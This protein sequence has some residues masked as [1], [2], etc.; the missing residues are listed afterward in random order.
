MGELGLQPS[1]LNGAHRGGC[2]G[3]CS[4]NISSFGPWPRPISSSLQGVGLGVPESPE[5]GAV[6]LQMSLHGAWGW[7]ADSPASG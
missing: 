3:L 2:P 5:G 4:M 7:D 1:V 6:S